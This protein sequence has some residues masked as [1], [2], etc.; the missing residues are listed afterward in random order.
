M[1]DSFQKGFSGNSLKMNIKYE[2]GDEFEGDILD[3][4]RH[5]SGTLFGPGIFIV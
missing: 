3:Q 1:G 4:K 2:N 5:G